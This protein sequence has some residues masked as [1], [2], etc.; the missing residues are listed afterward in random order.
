MKKLILLILFIVLSS[1][2]K[3]ITQN[4]YERTYS[5]YERD[6]AY[7][8]VYNHLYSYDMDTIPFSMW[9]SNELITDTITI[10][11]QMIRKIINEKTNYTF[12]LTKYIYPTSIYYNFLI[13]YFGKKKDL[14]YY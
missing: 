1:C 8:D 14:I 5:E 7:E 9:L 12:L 13:R 11:Q 10:N 3:Y 4:I 6:I 2:N